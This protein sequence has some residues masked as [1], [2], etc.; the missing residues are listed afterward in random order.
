MDQ[1]Q[2]ELLRAQARRS[3]ATEAR[4][5]LDAPPRSEDVAIAEASL[6]LARANL[7]E[8]Q[9][10]LEK[11]RLRAPIDGIVLRR[12]LRS[13]EAVGVTPPTPILEIGDTG[14]L[15]VRAEIGET[16][17]ARIAVGERVWVTADAYPLQRFG[18]VVARLGQ[19]VGHKRIH[20]DDPTDKSDAQT[21]EALIDLDPEARLPTGLRVDVAVEPAALAKN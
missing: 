8:Q 6:A 12:Y 19:R 1:T 9:A 15:R 4:A 5:L 21:L 20:I 17:I 10:L 14:R 11:T 13:G 2:A 18:G 7:A 16:D 3:A